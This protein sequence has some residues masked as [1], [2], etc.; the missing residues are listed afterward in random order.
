MWLTPINELGRFLVWFFA[1]VPAKILASTKSFLL[2]AEDILQFGANLRLWLALE[3][4]F[5]DYNWRGRLIG[6]LFRGFRVMA[7]LLVYLIISV[8]GLIAILVWWV[9]P[10]LI[11][12]MLK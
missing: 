4:L 2:T 6:F 9:L 12:T 11:F 1:I 7:T 5:G 8:I 10:W 3:P